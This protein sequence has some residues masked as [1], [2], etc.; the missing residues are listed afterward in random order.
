MRISLF[1][2]STLILLKI[3]AQPCD[4]S[5][6]QPQVVQGSSFIVTNLENN[7]VLISHLNGINWW[8]GT[9]LGVDKNA[10]HSSG[11]A[12]SQLIPSGSSGWM[13]TSGYNQSN[14]QSQTIPLGFYDFEFKE[15]G[16][17]GCIEYCHC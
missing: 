4:I 2:F 13:V 14:N 17:N 3:Q 1:I 15:G 5:G 9:S 6:W 16:T 11:V 12:D 10:D 7:A 8:D